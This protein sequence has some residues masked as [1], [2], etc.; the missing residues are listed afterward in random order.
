MD[1]QFLTVLFTIMAVFAQLSV[2]KADAGDAIA[3]IIGGSEYSEW[4]LCA[5]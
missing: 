3:G 1:R 4:I 5:F 2:V